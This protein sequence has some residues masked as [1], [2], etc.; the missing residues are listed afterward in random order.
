MAPRFAQ[1]LINLFYPPVCAICSSA[2]TSGSLCASCDQKT[3]RLLEIPACP[4]CGRS[5]GPHEITRERCRD[6]RRKRPKVS[7]IARV[8]PYEGLLGVLLRQYK[9]RHEPRVEPMLAEWLADAVR[10][11]PWFAC[12]E[13][14]VTVPTLW[15][16]RVRQPIYPAERLTEHLARRTGLPVAPL[17]RR[18]R[19]GPHQ[20][21]LSYT[22]RI[23]NVRG[24]FA[25]ARGVRLHDARLLLV[26][27]VRTTG[28]TLHEC[29]KVLRKSGAAAVYGAVITTAGAV[30]SREQASW[31][32]Y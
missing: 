18:V 22:D 7:G 19:A 31:A 27:D 5:V 11:A 16:R 24:A 6:C 8:G 29:A 21:G 12:V 14:L 13:A 23:A 30:T 25:L 1:E 28:A 32:R 3:G 10:R 15:R 4:T 9:Y 20:V 2:N 17:L 26:D